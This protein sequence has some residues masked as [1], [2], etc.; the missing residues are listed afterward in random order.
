MPSTDPGYRHRPKTALPNGAVEWGSAVLK[1]YDLAEDRLPVARSTARQAKSY[2]ARLPAMNVSAGFVILHRC[3]DRFHFL[4][5]HLWRSNNEIWQ[6]VHYADP[7]DTGFAPF[8]PAYPDMGQPR[9][10]LCV[11]EMGIAAHEAVVWQNYLN[12]DRST[13]AFA[14]W[15]SSCLT[16]IT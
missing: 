5:V 14:T 8:A 13:A 10:T 9:P 16:G 12:S 11:W 7:P 3:S 6:A 15:Q 1:W 4:L 2:L